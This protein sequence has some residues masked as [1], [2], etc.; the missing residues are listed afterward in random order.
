MAWLWGAIVVS[1]AAFAGPRGLEGLE[2]TPDGRKVAL[3]V[4]NG[5]YA[6]VSTLVQAP[7]DAEAIAGVL[8]G[9]GFTV[10]RASNTGGTDL[11]RAIADFSRSLTGASAGFF[12]YA[13][14]AV[15]IG[16]VNYMVPVDAAL[17]DPAYVDVDAVDVRKVQQALESSSAPIGV[18]VLDACRDNP[19]ASQWPAASRGGATRGLAQMATRGLLIAYATNPGNVA[20]DSG[21]YAEALAA[22]LGR[23]CQSLMDAFAQVRDQVLTTTGGSQVPWIGGSPGMAFSR[24][25]PAGCDGSPAVVPEP[26]TPVAVAAPADPERARL[27]GAVAAAE[28]LYEQRCVHDLGTVSTSEERKRCHARYQPKI[29]EAKDALDDYVLAHP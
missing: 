18:I 10:L 26:V 21:V 1:I 27:E 13:G 22:H 24:Y 12:Y 23:P 14:H 6:H 4:G 16:G 20:L 28:R 3:V 11:R 15:Q 19:F 7:R 29:D 2:A 5:D 9:L 25:P 17:R 8:E